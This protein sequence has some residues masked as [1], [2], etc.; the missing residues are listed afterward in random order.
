MG[1]WVG[2]RDRLDTV[3]NPGVEHRLLGR[4]PRNLIT[5]LTELSVP[6]F[7]SSS[8]GIEDG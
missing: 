6:Q 2:P 1:S 7:T 4:S 8:G 3:A 5:I